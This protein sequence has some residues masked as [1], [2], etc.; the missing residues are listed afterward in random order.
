MTNAAEPEVRNQTRA[1]EIRSRFFYNGKW[2]SPTG[3]GMGN[4][5]RDWLIEKI[6]YSEVTLTE[7]SKAAA[8]AKSKMDTAT[9]NYQTAETNRSQAKDYL[10]I[11]KMM[12]AEVMEIPQ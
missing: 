7:L 11:Q 6:A 8:S 5:G 4:P 9:K 2:H 12:L 3:G 10:D 1:E